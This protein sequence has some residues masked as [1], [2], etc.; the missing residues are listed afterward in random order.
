MAKIIFGRDGHQK[1]E[2]LDDD[3]RD[4]APSLRVTAVEVSLPGAHELSRAVITLEGVEA[5]VMLGQK[6]ISYIRT[7]F[8][9]GQVFRLRD[10]NLGILQPLPPDAENAG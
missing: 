1:L 9:V 7:P 4:M 3:G 5:D 2:I 10:G 6:H 8:M